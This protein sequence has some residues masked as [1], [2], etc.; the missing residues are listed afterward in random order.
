MNTYKEE[1]KKKVLKFHKWENKYH[2]KK[3]SPLNQRD[4]FG[5]TPLHL[6]SIENSA[7]LVLKFIQ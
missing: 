7:E 1:Y 2:Y 6:A 3:L 5:N 4:V